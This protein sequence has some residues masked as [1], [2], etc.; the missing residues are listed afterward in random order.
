[1]LVE[2]GAMT[3]TNVWLQKLRR[4]IAGHMIDPG[5]FLHEGVFFLWSS[6][7]GG[8]E[9]DLPQ[10]HCTKLAWSRGSGVGERPGKKTFKHEPPQTEGR[11]LV[12]I[13]ETK[14]RWPRSIQIRFVKEYRTFRSSY[15]GA[16]NH[17]PQS[18]ASRVQS[19]ASRAP[20][21]ERPLPP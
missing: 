21:R 9:T 1:M 15:C 7:F 11:C 20:E 10:A 17:T 3:R 6:C 4:N 12:T 2:L 16:E 5:A 13:A 14:T 18:R 8:T 19:R